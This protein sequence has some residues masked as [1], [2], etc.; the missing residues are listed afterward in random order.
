MNKPTR[1]I[2]FEGVAACDDGVVECLTCGA[3]D[4][5]VR[6][7]APGRTPVRCWRCGDHIGTLAEL[8]AVVRLPKGK[9]ESRPCHADDG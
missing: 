3:A 1:S 4:L 6:P 7:N 8:R 9:Y 2:E 5:H